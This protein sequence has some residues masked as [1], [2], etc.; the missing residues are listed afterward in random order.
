MGFLIDLILILTFAFTVIFYTYKGFI[1]SCFG[2][3]KYLIAFVIAHLFAPTLSEIIFDSFMYDSINRSVY[4]W[5]SDIIS[6]AEAQL[7]IQEFINKFPEFITK[8]LENIGV[9]LNSLVENPESA[10]MTEE[11]LSNIATSVSSSIA[12]FIST[13]LAYVSIFVVSVIVLT[14]LVFILDK[15]CKLPVLKQLNKTL[16]CIFGIICAIINV[17][18][19]CAIITL[20]LN[21][22]GIE[23]PELIP[24]II[25]DKTIVYNFISNINIFSWSL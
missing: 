12:E 14:I 13:A 25:S 21:I 8:L 15:I 19:V 17:M 1:K 7:N 6:N 20:V 9:S 18:A 10:P 16:G 23:K 4:N 22:V 3:C 24:D 11:A 2:L 5:M